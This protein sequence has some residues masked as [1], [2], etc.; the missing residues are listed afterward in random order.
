MKVREGNRRDLIE[1]VESVRFVSKDVSAS[2]FI[3]TESRAQRRAE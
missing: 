2:I 3:A 1:S